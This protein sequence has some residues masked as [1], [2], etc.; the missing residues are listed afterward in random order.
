VTSLLG[1]ALSR[2]LPANTL[3]ARDA[4]FAYTGNLYPTGAI[5]AP[6]GA[7]NREGGTATNY[8]QMFRNVMS[9]DGPVAACFLARRMLLSEA[10]FVWQ[11]MQRGRPTTIFGS[12][13][14]SILERPWP[15]GSTGQ[16]IARM[17]DYEGL[18]GNAFVVR[19]GE[20]RL[21]DERLVLPRPDWMV[22]VGGSRYDNAPV[23][24]WDL[25]AEV[26]GYL[27]FPGGPLSGRD[28]VPLLVEDVAHYA[29]NPDPLSRW[30]GMSWLTPVLREIDSDQ[31]A[32]DHKAQFFRNGASPQM[33]VSFDAAIK[34]EQVMKM[35]AQL[36][37]LTQGTSNAYKTL[38]LGGGADVTVVGRDLSQLDFA[39]TQGRDETRIAAAAGIHPVVLGL[40]EGLSGS[41]LNAGNFGAA[42]RLTGDRMLR[43]LW[44]FMCDALGTIIDV[45][46]P[47]NPT[48]GDGVTPVRL[49]I[50]ER[51]IPFLREDV[52]D[53]A[54]AQLVRA[55]AIAA[56]V[57]EGFEPDSVVAWSDADDLTLLS[58][59]GAVSVQLQK[60]G[61]DGSTQSPTPPGGNPAVDG[62]GGAGQL[63]QAGGAQAQQNGAAQNGGGR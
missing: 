44:R 15:N 36:N 3:D 40:S 29:P 31:A 63:P 4:V 10:R 56:L 38:Y 48:R 25:D 41:S 2:S 57:R 23:D 27:Y 28:P 16:L 33:V 35:A 61:P 7:G 14:L 6:T 18:A 52:K 30:R 22:I 26:I 8:E 17:S 62:A 32:T 9:S 12:P 51:D 55:Q 42:R 1:R 11:R 37:A 20:T 60:T 46:T 53:I 21:G 50:D 24:T 19:R 45:P 49:W 34:Q 13:E 47:P 58:H 5:A 39:N 43:P 59:T 54:E